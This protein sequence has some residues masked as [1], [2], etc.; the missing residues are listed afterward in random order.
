MS[1]IIQSDALAILAV[2]TNAGSP[3]KNSKNNDASSPEESP[4]ITEF[5][6]AALRGSIHIH[7]TF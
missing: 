2:V 6:M 5:K 7:S 1:L 3:I 4:N